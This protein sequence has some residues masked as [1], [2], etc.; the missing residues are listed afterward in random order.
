MRLHKPSFV[1]AASSSCC[2]QYYTTVACS[3]LLPTS[4]YHQIGH[5]TPVHL[6]TLKDPDRNP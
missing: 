5:R 3:I 6:R 4:N 1:I 2:Q